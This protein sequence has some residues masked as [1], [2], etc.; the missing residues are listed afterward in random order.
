MTKSIL[1]YYVSATQNSP[2]NSII[3][4]AILK[5]NTQ[6]LRCLLK[7]RCYSEVKHPEFE[8][9]KLNVLNEGTMNP[10]S[11]QWFATAFQTK[12]KK[13]SKHLRK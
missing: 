12:M 11:Q 7:L 13:S 4:D 5:L 1:L 10:L 6:T 8:K 2:F 9:K 3:Q